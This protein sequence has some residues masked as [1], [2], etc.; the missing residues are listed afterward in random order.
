MRSGDLPELELISWLQTYFPWRKWQLWN[1]TSKALYSTEIPHQS[2]HPGSTSKISQ[3]LVAHLS[4]R[5]I[6]HILPD[7]FLTED[8]RNLLYEKHALSLSHRSAME[9]SL[10]WKMHMALIQIRERYLK[11][12]RVSWYK[13]PCHTFAYYLTAHSAPHKKTWELLAPGETHW[14]PHHQLQDDNARSCR[15]CK[16]I[17]V[18]SCWSSGR[19]RK[20]G[21]G[22]GLGFPPPPCPVAL[23]GGGGASFH[24]KQ[25]TP[26]HSHHQQCHLELPS[27]FAFGGL[28]PV[29]FFKKIFYIFL[30]T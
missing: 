6:F 21:S 20:V 17:L 16:A 13:L 11:I 24:R 30:Q 9:C 1:V 23:L 29:H 28:P 8:I 7:S 25:Q 27:W 5:E 18:W 12:F 10:A 4:S 26:S 22:L 19:K 2:A 3:L 15:R 14:S